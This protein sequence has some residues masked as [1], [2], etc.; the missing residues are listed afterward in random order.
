MDRDE[1]ARVE[2]LEARI[3]ALEEELEQLHNERAQGE[4]E[5]QQDMQEAIKVLKHQVAV[6]ERLMRD[7]HVST[8]R[9]R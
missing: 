3:V 5:F 8:D 6:I 2:S 7:M 9:G 4:T 1:I